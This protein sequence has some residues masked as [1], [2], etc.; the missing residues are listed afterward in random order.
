ME[1]KTVA[2]IVVTYNRLALLQEEIESLRCQTF[3]S[4]QI[5]VINNGSTDGT[6]DWL[7]QQ[8]DIITITQGNLGGAGGF[9]TGMRYAAENG[10]EY[11]WV[12]DDDVICS[13]NALQELYNGYHLKE[14]IG[15]VCSKVSGTDGNA[16]NTPVV[17]DKLGKGYP[18]YYDMIE[19]Q[20][21][22]VVEATFVSVF[23]STKVIFELGLPI[24]EFF[25]W[26][27]DTEFTH[28]VSSHYDCYLCCK[29]EVVHKRTIQAGLTF[30][31]ETDPKRLRNYFY[32]FR[33]N[34][35][36]RKTYKGERKSFILAKGYFDAIYYYLLRG[37]WKHARILFKA[38][39]SFI[40]FCPAVQMPEVHK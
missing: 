23:L 16:M 8:K 27:D 17:G 38:M 9:N 6:L 35:Y 7:E 29:S 18:N 28:R 3:T 34:G 24:K 30:E 11:C 26:G 31:K 25:I 2:T 12:M 1:S 36:N 22:K 32:M 14:N 5:I 40:S 10:Y 21:I 37:R 4:H 15:F 13:P 33:N 20:M 19:H 39:K